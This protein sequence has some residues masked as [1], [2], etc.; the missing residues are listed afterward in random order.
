MS[1]QAAR[2]VTVATS[3][4]PLFVVY[5][6]PGIDSGLPNAIYA[7]VFLSFTPYFFGMLVTPSGEK[8]MVLLFRSSAAVPGHVFSTLKARLG[9][10]SSGL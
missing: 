10:W 2:P 7:G 6:R 4:F 1:P 8:P 3:A 5:T 9:S